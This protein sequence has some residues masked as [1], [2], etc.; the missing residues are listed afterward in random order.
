VARALEAATCARVYDK[1]G[2]E[3]L[4]LVATITQQSGDKHCG[5]IFAIGFYGA[6]SPKD[7][8]TALTTVIDL[9]KAQLLAN[10]NSHAEGTLVGVGAFYGL[11][12]VPM[13]GTSARERLVRGV[14]SA[15]REHSGP[16]AR[17]IAIFAAAA[18]LAAVAP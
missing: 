6:G 4:V 15:M 12:V 16:G 18:G 14:D 5:V 1:L 10:V 8:A 13:P 3:Y 11:V 7:Q 17:R 2:A 9:R